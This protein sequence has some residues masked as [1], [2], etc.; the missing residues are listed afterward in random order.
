MR[1]KHIAHTF[2]YSAPFDAYQRALN[3]DTHNYHNDVK[4]GRANRRQ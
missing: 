3:K 1:Y 4:I 2:R